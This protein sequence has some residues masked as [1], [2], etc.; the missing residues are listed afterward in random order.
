MMN[1]INGEM[2]CVLFFLLTASRYAVLPQT[3]LFATLCKAHEASNNTSSNDHQLRLW[4]QPQTTR[5]EL[6]Q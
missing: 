4:Q 6:R 1:T 5:F 2:K 3:M